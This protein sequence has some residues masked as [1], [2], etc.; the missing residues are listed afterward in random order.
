MIKKL[1]YNLDNEFIYFHFSGDNDM[2]YKVKKNIFKKDTGLT[3]ENPQNDIPAYLIEMSNFGESLMCG[4]VFNNL[5]AVLSQNDLDGVI[6]LVDFSNVIE[7]S[8][9]F[10]ESYVKYL[11]T[12]KNKV[13]TLNQNV[14][15]SNQFG[16]YAYSIFDIQNSESLL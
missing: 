1:N 5:A 10:C 9:N 2:V 14:D 4:N 6:L 8:S 3:I 13:I 11:L 12:T 15:V 7:V 16:E